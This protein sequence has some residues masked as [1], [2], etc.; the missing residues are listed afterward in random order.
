MV[1]TKITGQGNQKHIFNFVLPKLFS[2][3]AKFD[4]NKIRKIREAI[5]SVPVLLEQLRR[6]PNNSILGICS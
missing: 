1:S 5:P 4:K 2:H 3:T 6:D